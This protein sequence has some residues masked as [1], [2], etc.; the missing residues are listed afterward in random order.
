MQGGLHL[1]ADQSAHS[2]I[3]GLSCLGPHPQASH[4]RTARTSVAG[5]DGCLVTVTDWPCPGRCDVGSTTGANA[6]PVRCRQSRVSGLRQRLRCWRLVSEAL[7]FTKVDRA[8]RCTELE[9]HFIRMRTREAL[10]VKEN[11]VTLGRP[12]STPGDVVARIVAGAHGGQDRVRHCPRPQQRRCANC[13][14]CTRLVASYG[15]RAADAEGV[16]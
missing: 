8:S 2:A 15:P 10:Q 14:G 7:I 5:W 1:T 6:Y 12:R 16:H 11:G 13:A 9:R 4:T 3:L